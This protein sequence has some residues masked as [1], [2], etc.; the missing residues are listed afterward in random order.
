M[1]S[2][3]DKDYLTK[4]KKLYKINVIFHAAAYKHVNILEN[5]VELAI[6]NNIFGTFNLLQ[7]F[8]NKK[9]E[10][11]IISTDKAVKPISILGATK[12]LS[13]II[14]QDFQKKMIIFKD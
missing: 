5:N 12:R 14:S 6:K 3:N 8:N 2:I 13:E 10:I 7:I 9:Y 1:G 11:I 4:I